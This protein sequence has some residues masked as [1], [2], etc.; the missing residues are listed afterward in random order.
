MQIKRAN[1]KM[2]DVGVTMLMNFEKGIKLPKKMPNIDSAIT[3]IL[4]FVV[5]SSANRRPMSQR[6][7]VIVENM[8]RIITNAKAG[9]RT[10]RFLAIAARMGTC[11][12]CSTI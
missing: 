3:I 10:G 12:P 1:P 4:C 9:S 8:A 7:P 2:P 5:P 6:K 11:I